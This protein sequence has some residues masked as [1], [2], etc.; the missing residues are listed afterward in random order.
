MNFLIAAACLLFCP[1]QEGALSESKRKDLDRKLSG[2]FNRTAGKGKAVD[3]SWPRFG[4]LSAEEHAE[5]KERAWHAYQ[6]GS[7]AKK[8]AGEFKSR[9]IQS[10]KKIWMDSTIKSKYYSR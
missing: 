3:L 8:L 6:E 2:W 5:V 1:P 4:K 9:A 10:G 7:L